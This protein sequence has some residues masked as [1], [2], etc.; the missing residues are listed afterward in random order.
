M[1][2]RCLLKEMPSKSET[3]GNKEYLCQWSARE[4][5]KRFDLQTK[6]YCV[7]NQVLMLL[8]SNCISMDEILWIKVDLTVT[9]K[10]SNKVIFQLNGLKS[11]NRAHI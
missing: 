5:K 3:K 7:T 4:L 2:R 6:L 1:L 11:P 10:S 8:S 9:I